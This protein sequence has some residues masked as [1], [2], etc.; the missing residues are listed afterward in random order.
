MTSVH[1]VAPWRRKHSAPSRFDR[2]I[3]A[4]ALSIHRPRAFSRIS[5]ANS[6]PVPSAF[7]RMRTSPRRR[8]PFVSTLEERG[9]AGA[10]RPRRPF[11]ALRS[12]RVDVDDDVDDDD[13][14]D[15]PTTRVLAE[16]RCAFST[17]PLI[18]KPSAS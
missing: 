11:A 8:P 1:A 18:A 15:A 7:V 16:S 2:T 9:D 4:S 13:V 12:R 17:A 3:D 5:A 10:G 6:T 14:P